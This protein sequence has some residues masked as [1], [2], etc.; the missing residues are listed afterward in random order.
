MNILLWMS[1]IAA[2]VMS[3]VVWV[4]NLKISSDVNQPI[5]GIGLVYLTWGAFFV[6]ALLK[7][8][9]IGAH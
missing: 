9:T 4:A 5:D 6:L 2:I 7:L 1:F 8:M 3:F